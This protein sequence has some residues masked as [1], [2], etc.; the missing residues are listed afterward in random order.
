MKGNYYEQAMML[1]CMSIVLIVKC[2][3]GKHSLPTMTCRLVSDSALFQRVFPLMHTGVFQPYL[4][5]PNA[6][7]QMLKNSSEYYHPFTSL[8]RSA[9]EQ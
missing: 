4:T 9:T 6:C 2:L 7:E 5:L 3:I 8:D 1:F